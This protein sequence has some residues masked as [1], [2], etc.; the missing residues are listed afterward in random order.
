M[1]AN[2]QLGEVN[3]KEDLKT[4]AFDFDKP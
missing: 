4:R 1:L 2:R 3:K